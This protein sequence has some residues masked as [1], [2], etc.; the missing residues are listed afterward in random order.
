M[1]GAANGFEHRLLSSSPAN[2]HPST[3]SH[4]CLC[5]KLFFCGFTN[6]QQSELNRLARFA[7][8]AFFVIVTNSIIFYYLSTTSR[9]AIRA[10]QALR[11]HSIAD[12][13]WR[14]DRQQLSIVE[15]HEL[16]NAGRLLSHLQHRALQAPV[17][18]LFWLSV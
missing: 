8:S 1:L 11:L 12:S 6:G 7:G 18:N 15:N 3:S 16:W 14:S 4:R 2:Y 9:D 13:V 17:S 5:D 10:I